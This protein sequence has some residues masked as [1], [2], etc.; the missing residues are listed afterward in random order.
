[1]SAT[2]Y[3]EVRRQ[4]AKVPNSCD[5]T[6]CDAD[7]IGL[8]SHKGGRTISKWICDEGLLGSRSVFAETVASQHVAKGLCSR[9]IVLY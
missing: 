7:D 3:L 2:P 9:I 1:M 8:Q 5:L 6:V 4:A